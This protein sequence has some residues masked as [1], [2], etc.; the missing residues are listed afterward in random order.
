MF[1]FGYF[2]EFSDTVTLADP[3]IEAVARA[4]VLGPFTGQI[5]QAMGAP[6]TTIQTKS[7]ELYK[8]SHT[9]RAGTIAGEWAQTATS[10]LKIAADPLKGLTVGHVLEIGGEVVIIKDVD[11]SSGS[12]TVH[13]RGA[14]NTVAK[15]HANGTAFRVIGFAGNDEDLEKVEGVTEITTKATNYVQTVFETINWTKHGELMRK[16]LS[17]ANAKQILIREAEI[18]VAE[19]LASMAVRGVAAAATSEGGRYMSAGLLSQLS[20][21]TRGA[22][23]YNV[24]GALNEE[25]FKGALKILFD[26]GG[27]ADTVWCSPATKAYIN[28]FKGANSSVVLSDSAANHTAGGIYVDSYNY[29]GAILKVRVDA[30]MPDDR[31]ACVASGKVKKG[32]LEGDGLRLTDEPSR[33]SRVIRKALQ[34]S[35]GFIVED[36]GVDHVLITGITGGSSERIYTVKNASA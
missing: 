33:S 26:N 32:W 6:A 19:M 36:V 1:N 7:F 2:N 14:G 9:K 27:S 25:N 3:T 29:E 20:D 23:T 35:V 22:H 28:A 15:T 8:R 31:I 13:A 30:D 21:A 24:N 5:Y 4:I 12:V 18:R 34:G 10:G 17:D 16:G 11:R